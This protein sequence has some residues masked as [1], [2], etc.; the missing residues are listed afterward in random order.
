MKIQRPTIRTAGPTTNADFLQG[1]L[2]KSHVAMRPQYA[3]RALKESDLANKNIGFYFFRREDLAG[4]KAFQ[5]V[6]RAHDLSVRFCGDHSNH[7][8]YGTGFIAAENGYIITNSHVISDLIDTRPGHTRF[9]TRCE[10]N[11]ERD[12]EL[13]SKLQTEIII[14]GKRKVKINGAKLIH[15]AE[16][17]FYMDSYKPDMALIRIPEIAD[18]TNEHLSISPQIPTDREEPLF[19]IGNPILMQGEQLITIGSFEKMQKKESTEHIIHNAFSSAGFS[20]G[21]LVDINGNV[22]GLQHGAIRISDVDF[23]PAA[24]PTQCLIEMMSSHG[25]GQKS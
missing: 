17:A 25:V 5:N 16:R 20:G 3:P 7:N 9:E 1:S 14:G 10:N 24:V 11:F 22:V 6:C 23:T 12:R 19:L 15:L 8:W 2:R 4:D 21:P 13:L 18:I